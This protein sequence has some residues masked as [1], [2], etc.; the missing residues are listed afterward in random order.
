MRANTAL[1]VML[2]TVAV[3]SEARAQ[4]GPRMRTR[5]KSDWA[6]CAWATS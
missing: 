3:P 6:C 4:A 2:L 1:C 5:S